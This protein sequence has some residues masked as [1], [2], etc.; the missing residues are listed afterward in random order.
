SPRLTELF[1]QM[2]DQIVKTPPYSLGYP[3]DQAQSAYY[4]SVPHIT[5]QEIVLISRYLEGRSMFP[6]NTRIRKITTDQTITFEVLQASIDKDEERPGFK[7]PG[8]E[9]SVRIVRG[10]HSEYLKKICDELSQA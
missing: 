9:G 4:P 10:D 5:Q 1:T 6:E 3:S 2:S 8:L 7:I